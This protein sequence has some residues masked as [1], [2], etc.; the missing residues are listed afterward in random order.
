MENKAHD[1]IFH[2]LIGQQ[3]Y[4]NDDTKQ[5]EKRLDELSTTHTHIRLTQ[6]FR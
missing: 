6:G 3:I 1:D 2:V 5:L 4:G